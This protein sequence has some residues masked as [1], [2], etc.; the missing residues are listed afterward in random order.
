MEFST[1]SRARMAPACTAFYSSVMERTLSHDGDPRLARHIV[2][3]VVKPSPMGDYIT[4]VDKDSPAKIDL[5]VAA[6]IAH[7]R[8]R[9]A[10]PPRSPVFVI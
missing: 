8:A 9:Q 6:V 1:A 4:K 5:A 2:N 10:A 3:A 7:D